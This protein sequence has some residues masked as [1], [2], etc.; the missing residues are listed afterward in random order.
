[1]CWLHTVS[2]LYLKTK[3]SIHAG[4]IQVSLP[5]SFSTL[6]KA[7]I[8]K[9]HQRELSSSSFGDNEPHPPT[10]CGFYTE[11]RKNLPPSFSHFG[12]YLFYN[13]SFSWFFFLLPR[14]ILLC[15]ERSQLCIQRIKF[16]P[17]LHS[18]SRYT[19]ETF[20]KSKQIMGNFDVCCS[21]SFFRYIL[22]RPSSAPILPPQFAMDGRRNHSLAV[23][24]LCL[25]LS[26]L[27]RWVISSRFI[28]HLSSSSS[29]H[30]LKEPQLKAQEVTATT[31]GFWPRGPCFLT[32]ARYFTGSYRTCRTNFFYSS[33]KRSTIK[34]IYQ[35]YHC[36]AF[37]S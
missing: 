28:S 30:D 24:L 33:S 22:A 23:L 37:I 14:P 31:M 32:R 8:G 16:P 19:S 10:F 25:T 18:E 36:K 7:E 15:L 5:L 27:G 6:P 17:C 2:H 4:N 1:M 21:V 29:S 34:A 9:W 26:S 11:K 3:V 35:L 12:W 20:L 13:A